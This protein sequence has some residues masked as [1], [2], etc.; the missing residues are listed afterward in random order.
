MTHRAL[1]IGAQT[2]GLQG[3]DNDVAA[4][5]RALQ[6]RDFRIDTVTGSDATRDGI[7]DAYRKLIADTRPGD[8]CVVYYSGHGGL[9]RA[10]A[11]RDGTSR[12]QA[13]LQFIVPHD[14][15][16]ST[17]DDFRGITGTQLSALLAELTAVTPNATVV[18]DCCHSAHLSKK[19]RR[20]KALLRQ[21]TNVTYANVRRHV[22]QLVAN[23]LKDAPRD[24]HS[25]RNAVRIVAC[26]PHESAFESANVDGVDMGLLTDALTRRL[27]ATQDMRVNWLTLMD[28]IRRDVQNFE[29]A[30]RPE[31]EGPSNR[32]PFE[33]TDLTPLATL[34][35]VATG[36]NRIS[37]LGAPLIEVQRG[38]EFVIMPGDTAEAVTD[39]A[40]PRAIATATVEEV[41]QMAA[42]ATLHLAPG[43]D[44]VPVDA[45]AH[46]T[47]AGAPALPV[48]L[49]DGHPVRDDLRDAITGRPLVRV[50]DPGEET[51]VSVQVDAAGR[52]T[53]HDLVGPLHEPCGSAP[54]DIAR[55]VA[56][57]Q[58]LAQAA[59]L[60]RLGSDT[61]PFEHQVRVELGRVRGDEREPLPASGALLY[62]H[63][64][65]RIYIQLHNDGTTPVYVSL[66]DIGISS[67][68]GLLTGADPSGIQ[69]EPRT[70]YTYGWND[71]SQRLVGVDVTWPVGVETTFPRPETVLA[72]ISNRPVDV[73]VLQ[74]AGVRGAGPVPDRL[75]HGSALER[76]LAQAV[77]GAFRE[78]GSA[79][80]AKVR[81]AVVP[82]DFT[83]SPTA[84]PTAEDAPFLLDDR[85]TEPVRLLSPRGTLPGRVAVRLTDVVVHRNRAFGEA[86]VRL[87][88]VVL[89]G[90][91]AGLPVYRA[92]TV[93]CSN[94]RDG[95]R[96]PLDDLLI[97]H[98][99]AVDFL[100]IAIW[101][102]RDTK[103][104][105]S[106]GD[107][108]TQSLN[109]PALQAASVQLAGVAPHA[110]VAVATAGAC[111]TVVNTA[112]RALLG[113]IGPAIGL[114][115]TSLLAQEQ[116]GIGRHER[117]PQ[118]FSFTFSVE[119][120]A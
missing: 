105:L 14:Y 77:T 82:I 13:D 35:V 84:P 26:A 51:A 75:V 64:D 91:Q 41:V 112:Y 57:L 27:L 76:L 37:L 93:R 108:L 19:P 34:P 3:V 113:I 103:G 48:R 53:V 32:Q 61:A 6:P 65:E 43:W 73:S 88:T 67:R 104:S 18:L 107:L 86:D 99:P 9:L 110:A 89:T 38:D 85:P 46:R 63:R 30:Q 117:H 59:A 119:P 109:D 11:E 28:A 8:A 1:L 16:D 24:I 15:T 111:A 54:H 12:S 5:V 47:V 116:F 96:L 78:V 55:I 102:S 80:G 22:D 33:V 10:P 52:L 60:R 115:R 4:M 69:I 42:T 70:S 21:S 118:D 56:N 90:D 106:I 87:D 31:A 79:P 29:S 101:V 120:V 7:L 44:E 97:Y 74:Q 40:D 39:P 36:R 20:V 81:Y 68:I 114:Y 45:R 92:E 83:V 66:V 25:N 23:G 95:H 94:I 58:R 2:N 100:D 49:P 72:V 17:D 71:D 62:A 98:G 50:A